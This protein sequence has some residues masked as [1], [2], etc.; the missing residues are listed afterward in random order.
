[1][2][3]WVK[4]SS[5]FGYADDT[6]SCIKGLCI[7]RIL[8]M[9]EEDALNILQF[10]ASN[11]LVANPKKTAFMLLNCKGDTKFSVKI[12]ESVI[13]QVSSTK[14]LGM[15]ID[16]NQKWKNH[17][18][19]KGGLSTSLNQRLFVIKRL[20][21]HLPSKEI[22]KVAESLWTSKL[23]YGLQIWAEVRMTEDQPSHYLVEEAQKAQNNLLRTL[24]NKKLADRENIKKMLETQNILS[25]NQLAAQIKLT[26]MWKAKNVNEYPI[27]FRY[28]ETQPGARET[29]GNKAGRMIETG[30]TTK[31]K[32][33]LW[34]MPQEYETRPLQQLH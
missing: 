34:A 6:C 5:L 10:M 8:S 14:V 2:N 12:G 13:E 27:K 7:L 23:R 28:Q 3:A 31:S 4:Y 1:M 18:T 24:C 30:K 32:Q 15:T 16:D 22:R 17:V 25:V 9:L 11:G 33:V 20:K 26:E 19:G 29:R 21:N